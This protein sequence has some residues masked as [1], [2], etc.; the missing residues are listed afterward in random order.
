MAGIALTWINAVWQWRFKVRSIQRAER[1]MDHSHMDH[2]Q[3]GT[4]HSQS[5]TDKT[6]KWL[7]ILLFVLVGGY[8]LITEHRAHV[9]GWWPLLF[10]LACPLMHFFMHSHGGHD[11]ESSRPPAN[12][13]NGTGHQH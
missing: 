1:Q 11:D 2:P 4:D 9:L 3:N 12:R 7:A 8:Y 5:G 6:L 10:V 13:Q